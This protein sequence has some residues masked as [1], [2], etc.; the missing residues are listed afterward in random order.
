VARYTSLDSETAH[1]S[2]PTGDPGKND[3]YDDQVPPHAPA[4]PE[5]E[6]ETEDEA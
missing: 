1:A 2:N 4:E 5:P 3:L 6:P